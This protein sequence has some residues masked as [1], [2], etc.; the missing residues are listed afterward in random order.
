MS[1]DGHGWAWIM[2]TDGQ[3]WAKIFQPTPPNKIRLR[4]IQ[5]TPMSTD[6]HQWAPMGM[7]GLPW[8]LMGTDEPESS[9]RPNTKKIRPRRNQCPLMSMD[10]H[11]WAPMGHNIPANPPKQNQTPKNDDFDLWTSTCLLLATFFL[12]LPCAFPM[13]KKPMNGAGSGCAQKTLWAS[14]QTNGSN[15]CV[16]LWFPRMWFRLC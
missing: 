5:K 14:C 4:R 11:R 15:F 6:G 13:N 2:G 16:C 10:G 9:S 7:D 12:C 1:T 3:Q 8:A